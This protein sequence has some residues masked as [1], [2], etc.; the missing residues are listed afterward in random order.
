M[1]YSFRVEQDALG[2]VAVP[3]AALYGGQTS[4][5]LGNFQISSL[6]IHPA[7]LIGLAE[8]KL[9]AATANMTAGGLT[10]KHATAIRQAAA[11]IIAG[12]TVGFAALHNEKLG[13]LGAA[14]LAQRAIQAKVSRNS[15]TISQ[16]NSAVL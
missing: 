10:K 2:T 12:R 14:E 13:F 7:L 8:I 16:E 1:N 6:R 3:A 4:R 11:E 5:A 15:R 9:A